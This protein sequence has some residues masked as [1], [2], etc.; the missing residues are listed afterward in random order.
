MLSQ[1]ISAFTF[2]LHQVI[3]NKLTAGVHVLCIQLYA[4][5]ERRVESSSCFSCKHIH[6]LLKCKHTKAVTAGEWHKKRCNY[7]SPPGTVQFVHFLI[8]LMTLNHMH[9]M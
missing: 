6:T 1:P 9:V 5:T 3:S 7:C 4:Y 8:S 2:P